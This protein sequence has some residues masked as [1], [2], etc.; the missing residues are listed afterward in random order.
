[1][2]F[3]GAAGR[4]CPVAFSIQIATLTPSLQAILTSQLAPGCKS[5]FS[6]PA[7][8]FRW[9]P[10]INFAISVPKHPFCGPFQGL[11]G[12]K[13]AIPEPERPFRWPLGRRFG[14]SKPAGSFRCRMLGLQVRSRRG[15]YWGLRPSM[16]SCH[17]PQ[18]LR[19][20]H[21]GS[22]ACNLTKSLPAPL[23][24]NRHAWAS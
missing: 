13:I 24:A 5:A 19:L 22:L 1:M 12:L 7:G 2:F 20:A 17:D 16:D 15:I 6:K 10:G 14:F 18:T 21:R 8:T 23:T 11:S 9:P 3:S 4:S